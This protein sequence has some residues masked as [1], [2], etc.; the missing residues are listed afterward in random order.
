MSMKKIVI[1]SL[2]AFAMLTGFAVDAAPSCTKAAPAECVKKCDAPKACTKQ[3]SP[4]CEKKCEAPKPE[5]TKK[6]E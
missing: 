4:K 1:A 5:C 6:A 2:F 3:E